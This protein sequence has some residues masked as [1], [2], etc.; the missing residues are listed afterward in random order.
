MLNINE[1][2]EHYP[3]HLKSRLFYEYM[4][5]EYFQ[6]KMLDIIY[7]SEWASKLS[8][9]GG[10]SL[11]ILHGIPRFSEDL[12][13]DC[14]DLGRDAF[15]QMTDIVI[16]RIREEGIDIMADDKEKDLKLKAFRRN[17]VFPGLL[18]IQNISGHREQKFLIKIESEPHNFD[19]V[20][21][22]PIVQKFNIFTQLNATPVDI[23]L[24]MKI[25]AVLER[26]KGRDYYDCIFLM[27]KT[28]PNYD[29]LSKKFDINS[30][31]DLKK[32]ILDSCRNVDFKY[33]AK[34]F[35]RLT[36]RREEAKKI[37]I[38]PSYIEEYDF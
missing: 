37:E 24:S 30:P 12:D 23:L 31:Y 14:F 6:Y 27:G 5:K 17:L 3:D 20:P 36:Y 16:N 32:R 15:M 19:Y 9:I 25:G 35:E 33:K 11:R 34:D 4:L 18:F 13:F 26:Q 28:K 22:K 7:N 29:Y 2:K 10:T 38:F 1:I 8:F 21:Y